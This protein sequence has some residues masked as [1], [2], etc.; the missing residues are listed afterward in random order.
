[1]LVSVIVPAF[2]AAR[3]LSRAVES[4]VKT[5]YPDLEIII[6]DDGSRDDTLDVAHGLAQRYPDAVVVTRHAD[7]G[8]HGASAS[9]NVALRES[10]G[11]AVCFLDADDFV[12]PHRFRAAVPVLISDPAADGVYELTRVLFETEEAHPGWWRDGRRLRRD[13][14]RLLVDHSVTAGRGRRCC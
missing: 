11:E 6:V 9:R 8:H 14:T 13:A 1:M 2:N 7:R 5:G 10:A 4:L 3:Y 12:Y